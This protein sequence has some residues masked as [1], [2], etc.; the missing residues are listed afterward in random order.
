MHRLRCIYLKYNALVSVKHRFRTRENNACFHRFFDL[1]QGRR[2]GAANY[3]RLMMTAENHETTE[4]TTTAKRKRGRPSKYSQAVVDKI[5]LRLVNGESLRKICADPELPSLVTIWNWYRRE[6]IKED[7]LKQFLR[8]RAFQSLVLDGDMQD[9]A[10]DSRH[11]IRLE[12]RD[13]GE[14]VVEVVDREHIQR[15]KLRCETMWKRMKCMNPEMFAEKLDVNHEVSGK[16][17]GPISFR[18]AKPEEAAD[19]DE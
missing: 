1:N 18:W 7:F 4:E 6:D 10:D 2:C 5:C 11:D 17:G 8:A 15:S 19:D 9:V 3:G 13:D 14:G 16:G 12:S